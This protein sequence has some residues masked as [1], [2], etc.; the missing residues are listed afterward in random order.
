MKKFLIIVL[1]F[2]SIVALSIRFGSGPLMTFLGT[3]QRA[4]LRVEANKKSEVFINGQ[5]VGETPY[6]DENL[7]EAEYLLSLKSLDASTSATESAQGASSWQGYVKLNNG[8][9]SVV[10]REI[11]ASP[12]ISSGEIITLKKSINRGSKITVV[13]V[14]AESLVAVDG[15]EYG[16]TPITIEGISGGEHQFLLSKE[17]Y[18]NRSIRAT[19]VDGY[20]LTLSVDLAITEPDLSKSVTIPLASTK[21]VTVKQTPVGFLRVREDATVNA[22]EVTRVSPGEVLS[23]LEE[24]PGWSKV[25]MK[26]GKEGWVSSAYIEKK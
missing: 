7:K 18:L 3:N 4:G 20:D 15:K 8:T 21:E 25:R 5:L 12:V 9:L 22:K 19:V 10:N 23:L 14:P 11:A 13:S 24:K 16:R 2:L 1:A 17:N 6:Q 26:D